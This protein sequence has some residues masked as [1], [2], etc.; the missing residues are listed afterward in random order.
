MDLKNKIREVPNFPKDGILFYDITTLLKDPSGFQEVIN[1]LSLP[2]LNK[3]I[4]KVVAIESRGFI[5]GAPLAQRLNAGFVPVRKPGKLPSDKIE[6]KYDLEYGSD[7][8]AIH[9]DAIS[10]G[11]KT[12]I[13]DDLL[14]TGGT[15]RSAINLVTRLGGDIL[16][17]A[18]VI[19]LAALKGREKI[20][21][22]PIVSLITYE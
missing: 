9:Q 16:G 3:G 17:I 15:M 21:G 6:E 4:E 18:V 13:V 5:L 1:R 8:L 14:A 22:H 20:N 7:C 2:F 11:E 12:L 19:E 10:A